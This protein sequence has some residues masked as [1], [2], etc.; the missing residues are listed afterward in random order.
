[1]SMDAADVPDAAE[2]LAPV[3]AARTPGADAGE[4]GLE[5]FVEIAEQELALG[6][7]HEGRHEKARQPRSHYNFSSVSSPSVMLRSA[8]SDCLSAR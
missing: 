3:S 2:R 8:E 1:M 4:R 7:G 5:L 6:I